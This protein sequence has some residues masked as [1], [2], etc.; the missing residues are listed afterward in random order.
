MVSH[1]GLCRRPLL[2]FQHKCDTLAESDSDD[3][4]HRP[5]RRRRIEA[6]QADDASEGQVCGCGAQHATQS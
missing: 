5:A 1:I 2:L 4:D 6:A 3:S